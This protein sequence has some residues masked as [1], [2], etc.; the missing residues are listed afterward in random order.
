[1]GSSG[2]RRTL[3]FRHAR[4]AITE[5]VSLELAL[6]DLF[7]QFDSANGDRRV[8]ESFEPQHRPSPLFDSPWSCSMRLFRYWLDRTITLL[9]SSPV[10]LISRTAM[11]CRMGVQRDLRWFTC[12]L[13]RPAEKSLC[14][15]HITIF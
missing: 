2:E 8:V 15:I 7:R 4:L 6:L 12:F 10:S 13:Y 11:R 5:L 3:Q 1:M 14:R 9:D